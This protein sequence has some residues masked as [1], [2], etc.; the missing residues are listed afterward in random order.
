MRAAMRLFPDAP[1]PFV[2]L[3]TGINPLPYPVPELPEDAF[4]RLPEPENLLSLQ[5]AA[6]EAYGMGDTSMVAAA[7][8]TQNL[9][10]L[11]PRLIPAGPVNVLSPTYG[12]HAPAWVR[13]GHQVSLV[14]KFE[15]L[16]SGAT[17]VLCNP[18]NPDGQRL[19]PTLLVELAK[20]LAARDG[21]LIVDEA[22]AEF[23]EFKISV[24]RYL[25][26]D[27]LIVLRS[28]GKAYG[29]AGLRLGFALA[30]PD[31]AGV[32]RAALGPWPVSGPAI[33]IGA[34]A[35]ADAKWREA[36]GKRLKADCNRLDRLLT[37]GGFRVAGG[38][39]LFRL[40]SGAHAA[41]TWL[42]LCRAGVLVRSF[43]EH[44]DWLRFGLP[45]AEAEWRRLESVL[46]N[47]ANSIEN[48]A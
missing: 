20:H 40:A 34:V 22:F 15:D 29:L 42:R 9:I 10:E 37:G 31:I 46:L 35:L 19:E 11:L 16:K 43:E 14:D 2:D 13:A 1:T 30:S 24:A 8:G 18:N 25:P 6:A 32:I 45:G 38:T 7:P 4:S 5:S 44:P 33:A 36:A 17:A 28:F 12:E 41:E 3:S 21:W 47:A 39:S 48:P 26:Q 23:G 27:R